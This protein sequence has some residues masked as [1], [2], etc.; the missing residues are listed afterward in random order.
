VSTG[1][2]VGLG[3]W[4]DIGLLIYSQSHK[5]NMPPA[6]VV[7]GDCM[8]WNLLLVPAL[9]ALRSVPAGQEQVLVIF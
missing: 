7:F 2:V 6:N 3:H 9:S 1:N 8:G 5:M 4:R